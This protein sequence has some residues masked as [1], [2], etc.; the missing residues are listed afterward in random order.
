MPKAAVELDAAAEILPVDAIAPR[1][2]RSLEV[3][4]KR[5]SAE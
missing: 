5:T 4:A 1:L 3:A 2:L